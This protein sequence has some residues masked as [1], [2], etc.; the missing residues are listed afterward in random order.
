[1][2]QFVDEVRL[3]VVAGRGGKGAVSFRREKYVPAGGPDG[4]D[5]GRGGDVVVISSST[6]VSLSAYAAPVRYLAEP[7]GNGAGGLKAGRRG[8]DLQ[9][10]VPPGTVVHD[11]DTGELIGDLDR[12]G[13]AVVVAAGGRGGRG[14][15]RFATSTRR[16]PRVGELGAPGETRHIR[17][18][19][20]LIADIGLIGLPNAGKSALL[21]ALTGAH[22]K[23]GNYPFTTLQPNL[24]VAEVDGRPITIADVPGLIAGAH[25]GAGLGIAFLRHIERTR[26][27]VHVVDAS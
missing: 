14:N 12:S 20:K 3:R 1:M 15:A 10:A 13:A 27:L 17:L 9:L 25:D 5:G 26:V 2:N 6:D 21:A 18:E 22:P 19:L 8:T 24:G 16:A 23:I 11:A 4:G 7:G